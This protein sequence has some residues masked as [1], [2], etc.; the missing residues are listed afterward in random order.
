MVIAKAT[1]PA[2]MPSQP[3]AVWDAPSSS[4]TTTPP[5]DV[6]P[7]VFLSASTSGPQQQQPTAPFRRSLPPPPHPAISPSPSPTPT[8][9]APQ[10]SPNTTAA[11]AAAVA[12]ANAASSG[13][14][15]EPPARTSSSSSTT[16][17]EQAGVEALTPW[18]EEYVTL[19]AIVRRLMEDAEGDVAKENELLAELR[20][21]DTLRDQLITTALPEPPV[22]HPHS[23]R[24]S[25]SQP[26]LR[27]PTPVPAAS[28]PAFLSR[29]PFRSVS[30]SATVPAP[31]NAPPP[32]RLPS[33]NAGAAPAVVL[34]TVRQRIEKLGAKLNYRGSGRGRSPS[35]PVGAIVAPTAAAVSDHPAAV[36][37]AP[38][39]PEALVEALKELEDLRRRTNDALAALRT[40]H[41]G[42]ELALW[43]RRLATLLEHAFAFHPSPPPATAPVARRRADT[44][45][46]A[47]TAVDLAA[48]R[49][50]DA[51]TLLVAALSEPDGPALERRVRDALAVLDDVRTAMNRVTP[52][53]APTTDR[54]TSPDPE[55]DPVVA[56][57]SRARD[58]AFWLLTECATD[59]R[60]APH[61]LH[62]HLVALAASLA[63][64]PPT[65]VPQQ[66]VSTPLAPRLAALHARLAPRAT[67]ARHAARAAHTADLRARVAAL[68]EAVAA[69]ICAGIDSFA[70]PDERRTLRRRTRRRVA[71]AATGSEPADDGDDSDD[72]SLRRYRTLCRGEAGGAE[73]DLALEMLL[74]HCP[75]GAGEV[76]DPPGPPP[77]AHLASP[78]G[79]PPPAVQR[80][81][82]VLVWEQEAVVEPV[83][84]QV[85]QRP[86]AV[87][88]VGAGVRAAP[89]PPLRVVVGGVSVVE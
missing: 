69:C 50:R 2:V 58:T 25:A 24:P 38:P 81:R 13:T 47:A 78:P 75:V 14:A 85:G 60:P 89:L 9:V 35:R 84:V 4:A 40:A 20:N 18:V 31:T 57:L 77:A 83:G 28:L 70:A 51:A 86:R 46:A 23:L 68:E 56:D 8:P 63:P 59:P 74:A 45:A 29:S 11:A 62:P 19:V 34:G 33:P 55:T 87:S 66:P 16:S 21:I 49:T 82:W 54:P 44:A 10:R 39:P 27:A 61:L 53:T 37:S 41:R 22:P 36:T 79:S 64:V 26:D 52:T 30:P 12:A 15:P 1:S 48:R 67:A 7:A 76:Q 5:S 32:Q 43:R 65:L 71:A 6:M 72:E 42:P 80:G 88:A 73:L 3:V 17:L